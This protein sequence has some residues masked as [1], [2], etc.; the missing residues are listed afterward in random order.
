MSFPS[1]TQADVRDTAEFRAYLRKRA[2]GTLV[3]EDPAFESFIGLFEDFS[4]LRWEAENA[5]R[6]HPYQAID[7]R[8]ALPVAWE[9]VADVFTRSRDEPPVRIVTRIAQA[10]MPLVNSILGNLRKVL[11][12]TRMQVPVSRARQMDSECLRRFAMLPGQT[13]DEKASARRTILGVERIESFDTLE[14]RV[15]KAFLSRCE[16]EAHR[17]LRQF[18]TDKTKD[19]DRIRAVQRMEAAFHQELQDEPWPSVRDL[20]EMPQPN[21]VLRQDAW[22]SKLWELYRELVG[23]DRSMERIW[24]YRQHVFSDAAGLWL[25]LSLFAHDPETHV[26][27]AFQ[28]R[29]DNRRWVH[30]MP[31][32]DGGH[33]LES[34]PMLQLGTKADETLS[35]CETPNGDF[36]LSFARMSGRDVRMTKDVI[37]SFDSALSRHVRG[38]CSLYRIVR[39]ES[40]NPP[41]EE[42]IAKQSEATIRIGNG[43]RILTV[44]GE[45][46]QTTAKTILANGGSR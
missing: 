33:F 28:P 7:K 6:R 19:S 27:K 43:K 41:S 42:A 4:A 45:A 9:T 25:C 10:H 12:R 46:V 8:K 36:R 26:P 24:P 3:S 1:Q 11:R 29:F 13:S 5:H 34:C 15:M 35:L 16:R 21:Y 20:Y 14:N 39:D 38:G 30:A 17:Y 23:Q 44:L 40:L 37:V 31:M 2:D 32:S 22:Y 18:R